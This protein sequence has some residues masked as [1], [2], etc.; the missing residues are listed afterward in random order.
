MFYVLYSL[1]VVTESLSL[2]VCI[3]LI[4]VKLCERN[5]RLKGGRDF[6][7]VEMAGLRCHVNWQ[8]YS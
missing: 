8:F 1:P 4:S 2:L 5:A 3:Y 7:A 6:S